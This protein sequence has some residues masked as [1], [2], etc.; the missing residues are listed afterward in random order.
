MKF[1]DFT[2]MAWVKPD[3]PGHKVGEHAFDGSEII[4]SDESGPT[5]EFL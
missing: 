3:G 1:D 5:S 4:W 2:F